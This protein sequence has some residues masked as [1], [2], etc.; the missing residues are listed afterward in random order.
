MLGLSLRP[1]TRLLLV[2]IGIG[3]ALSAA[4][5]MAEVVTIGQA[6][7]TTLTFAPIYAAMELGFFKEEDIEP[8]ILE[9]LGSS[10]LL[11]QVASKS[12]TIGFP[13]ADVL[14][15]SRQPG[16][17]ALPLKFFYNA[18]RSSIWE[19]VVPESS[20]IKTVA[21]LRGKVI[22]VGALAN[23]N[24]PITRA[25]FR[26][27]GMAPTKDYSFAAIGVGA[28]AFRATLNGDVDAY[29]T[30]D[31]NIAA[32]EMTGAKIRRLPTAKKYADLF[33]NGFLAHEDTVKQN[34]KVL[35]GFGRALT[36]GV[37]VCEANGDWCVRNFWKHNPSL[38]PGQGSEEEKMAVG[39]HVLAE[40][41]KHYLAFPE[42][43]PRQFGSF[44]EQIWKD[45]VVALYDGGELTTKD[46]DIST[47]YT[48]VFVPEFNKLDTEKIRA[49]A[50]SRQ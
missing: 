42:G 22:G 46:I 43:Q 15:M 28:P 7:T 1:M 9:F 2:A 44:D 12:V 29:N 45:F 49:L 21:D 10:I 26:E 36:K 38:K 50:K 13:N 32:F 23:G 39:R 18:A 35:I 17:D 24:V 4:P 25:M 14:I 41:M 27:L 19:F 6:T 8:K 30:F 40:R 31:V 11:P 16:R 37:L 47:L 20:P 34:P 48:N 33:S 3:G 5:V